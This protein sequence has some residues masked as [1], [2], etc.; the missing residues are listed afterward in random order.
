MLCT[1]NQT[2]YCG[3]GNR[4]S[5]YQ[6]NSSLISLTSSLTSSLK[7]TSTSTIKSLSS[8]QVSTTGSQ[9]SSTSSKVTSSTSP[10]AT[11][12][13][14]Y[15]YVGCQTDAGVNDRTLS[16]TSFTDTAM[17]LEICAAF[18]GARGYTYF[19]AEYAT[20]CYCGNTVLP[21]STVATDGRCNMNCAGSVTE[22]CGGPGGLSLYKLSAVPSTTTSAS[23]PEYTYVGCQNDSTTARTLSSLVITSPALTVE[24]CTSFCAGYTYFGLEYADEC[25][26]GNT[27]AAGSAL[28]TD[29]RCSMGTCICWNLHLCQTMLTLNYQHAPATLP[30]SAVVPVAS[31]SIN[32]LLSFPAAAA[33]Y[34]PQLQ[35]NLRQ[36][37]PLQCPRRPK[38]QLVQSPPA[39]QTLPP[40]P[41][42][43]NG[44]SE[45]IPSKDATPTPLQPAL[46]PPCKLLTT[47]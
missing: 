14:G 3:S 30:R 28:V 38:T 21:S 46:L 1:G 7:P 5:L 37:L 20:E 13:G 44:Q 31:R 39:V 26:C 25:Y 4:L 15:A 29:G 43:L 9:L 18:C 23:I 11:L 19:G 12:V 24:L 32:W 27:L 35:R 40:Q 33:V 2:E 36:A 22:V 6:Y 41:Q 8:T 17:T 45:H 10:T 16:S 42:Q 34:H 47:R